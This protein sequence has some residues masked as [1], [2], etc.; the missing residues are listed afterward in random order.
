M[1]DVF[2]SEAA[3]EAFRDAVG[4]IPREVGIE[5]G[6]DFFPAHTYY[7]ELGRLT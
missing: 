6:P 4:T 3:V 2:D 5:E 1:I 7:S